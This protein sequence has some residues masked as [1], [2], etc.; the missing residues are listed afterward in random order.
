MV[1]LIGSMISAFT[2]MMAKKPMMATARN[3]TSM[4]RISPSTTGDL[5]AFGLPVFVIVRG[6]LTYS[7]GPEVSV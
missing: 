7:G 3:V 6:L 1:R 4:L 2:V 5:L